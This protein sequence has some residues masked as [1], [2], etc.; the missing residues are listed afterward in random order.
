MG[1][2]KRFPKGKAD[3]SPSRTLLNAAQPGAAVSVTVNDFRY[4]SFPLEF[5]V[6]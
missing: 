4:F 3:I 2:K 6:V 5:K 1:S